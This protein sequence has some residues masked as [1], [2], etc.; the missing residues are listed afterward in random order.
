MG[1]KKSLSEVEITSIGIYKK[2]G[3]SNRQIAKEIGRSE[4]V[5]RNFLKKGEDYG[6]KKETLY[7]QRAKGGKYLKKQQRI[8]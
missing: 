4:T 3:F 8:V 2:M 5:I 6:K 7:S 1:R